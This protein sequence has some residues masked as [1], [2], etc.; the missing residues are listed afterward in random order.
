[1]I[2][3]EGDKYILYAKDGKK[4]LGTHDTLKKAVAQERAIQASKHG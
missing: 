4:K 3:K 2:R 1:M